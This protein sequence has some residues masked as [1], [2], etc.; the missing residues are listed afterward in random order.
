MEVSVY[1][2]KRYTN[3]LWSA[4]IPF[5]KLKQKASTGSFPLNILSF[6]TEES[7]RLTILEMLT[8]SSSHK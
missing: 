6:Q 1:D 2:D 3:I 4:D 8:Y 5:I 7:D